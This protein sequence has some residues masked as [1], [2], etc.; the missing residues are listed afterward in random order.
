[1]L[2]LLLDSIRNWLIDLGAYRLF[3]VLDQLQFRALAAAALSFLL[4]LLLG[5]RTIA[6]LTRKKIGD[7][8]LTDAQALRA[9]ANAKANTP[10]MGGIL[11]VGSILTSVLLLADLSQRYVQLGIVV[12]V[13]LAVLGSMDDWLKLTAKSR[14]SSSRQGLYAWEKLVFQLG[15]GV[16]VGYFLFASPPAPEQAPGEARLAHVVNLPFQKTYVG[17]GR[18]RPAGE[19]APV[20]APA[21][22]TTAAPTPIEPTLTVNPNLFYFSMPIFI[23]WAMLFITGMSNAVNITDGMDGLAGGISAAVM[24]GVFV[25]ALIAGDEDTAKYL[26]VPFLPG[27]GELAVLAGA[28]AGACLGFMWWNCSPA[29]VFMGDTGALSLGGIVGYTAVALRQEYVVIVMSGVFLAEIASVALQVGYFRATGGKRI[30]RCAPYHHHLHMGGWPE[31]QVV[32]RLWI[33]SIILV[34]MA[35]ASVKLR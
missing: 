25:L 34:V 14:G 29:H 27:A 16:L 26:L 22:P 18:A 2:Y 10:T 1:M 17:V 35:L 8:G 23:V 4:V 20:P 11:I 19:P 7:S 9:T 13:W 33:I 30:F 21:S 5:R 28:T 24:M 3:S 6:W 31:P 12:V 15:L 32:T